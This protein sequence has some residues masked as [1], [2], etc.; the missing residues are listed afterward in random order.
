LKP[1]TD[2]A[3]DEYFE[4][5]TDRQGKPG[6]ASGD[7][8]GDMSRTDTG[9][10]VWPHSSGPVVENVFVREIAVVLVDGYVFAGT[11][12]ESSAP[13]A[14]SSSFLPSALQSGLPR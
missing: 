5:A 4:P 9:H 7:V 8:S 11:L 3:I 10:D 1:E 13:G 6:D 12:S 14:W 2:I